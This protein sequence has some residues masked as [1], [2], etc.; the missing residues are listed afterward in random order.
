MAVDPVD[1]LLL[2][3]ADRRKRTRARKAA[4]KERPLEAARK[5]VVEELRVEELLQER[6][7][8]ALLRA[9]VCP[10]RLLLGIA[11]PT[12]A[13]EDRDVPEPR[14]A[15]LL[16]RAADEG[17]VDL[18]VRKGLGRLGAEH[19]VA[20]R[21][22]E[23]VPVVERDERGHL[24]AERLVHMLEV[25]LE[26][27]EVREAAGRGPGA[28]RPASVL[29]AVVHA[30]PA[31]AQFALQHLADAGGH[32]PEPVDALRLAV[33][34]IAPDVEEPETA[35]FDLG[36][37]LRQVPVAEHLQVRP[38]EVAE[39]VRDDVRVERV[40][41]GRVV[42]QMPD[43]RELHAVAE[44]GA[45]RRLHRAARLVRVAARVHVVRVDGGPRVCG[46]RQRR[47]REKSGQVHVAP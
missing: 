23:V 30:E 9:G 18:A 39:P 3:L 22:Q 27:E 32:A 12:P 13:V 44:L 20:V 41:P 45:V 26:A 34:Q 47:A 7:R 4:V 33:R 5:A 43:G 36:D 10:R 11:L 35:P 37:D 38:D 31:V 28:S 42:R 8:G 24:V 21:A 1:R 40:A 19:R 15:V 14:H 17:V 29:F 25:A 16:A 46:A 6:E 2:D